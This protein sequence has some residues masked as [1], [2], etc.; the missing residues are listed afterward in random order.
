[1]KYP[2]I[3]FLF[4][5]TI[6]IT[7]FKED[8]VP[9]VYKVIK[10]DG[11]IIY[12]KTGKSMTTGD[13]FSESEKL[14]FKTEESRAAV[15]S[16]L[17]GRFILSAQNNG[18]SNNLL[19]A[20]NNVKT[21]AGALLSLIDLQNYFKGDFLVVD[22]RKQ[23]IAEASFPMNETNFFYVQYVYNGEEIH[24]K[25][26]YDGNELIISKA[27]L[28]TIDGK[29]VT[30]QDK[31]SLKLWYRNAEE[32]KSLLVSEFICIMPAKVEI[33]KELAVIIKE[34]QKGEEKKL[35]EEAAGFLNDFYGSADTDYVKQL[36]KK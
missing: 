33:M 23:T 7:A 17:K 12:Q 28:F 36:L 5:T 19:P 6:F 9:N 26:P 14:V 20:M 4:F 32:K 13:Q 30:S 29:A 15:I 3:L 1:M 18:L 21:R 2:T 27:E 11:S 10:V 31:I 8:P 16:S 22:E 24:K 25:L 34:H 35:I